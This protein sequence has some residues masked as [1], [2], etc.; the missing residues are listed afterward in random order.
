MRTVSPTVERERLRIV[1]IIA[2]AFVPLLFIELALVQSQTQAG[3]DSIAAGRLALARSVASASDTFIDGNLATLRAL[4][5]TRSVKDADVQNVNAI[6]TPILRQDPN[7][8]TFGLSSAD[9]WNLSSFTTGPHTV[10]ISD[11][12]YFQAALA[13]R[14]GVGS[15]LLTRGSL[16][17]KTIV[18]AVPVTFNDGTKGVLSGALSLVNLERQ[19][20]Q[21]VPSET[22]DLRMVDRLGHEFIG[23]NAGGDSLPDENARPEVRDGLAGQSKALVAKDTR[24]RD[25]LLAYAP[26]VK[27]GWVVILS[28]PIATAFTLPDRLGQTAFVLTL[29]GVA[30]ALAIAWYLGGR[31]ARSYVEVDLARSIAQGE[32]FRLYDALRHAPARVGLLNGPDLVYAVATPDQL[33]QVGMGEE[34]VIGK[35]F[36][37]VDPEPT[38]RAILERVYNTGEPFIAKE[39]PS[40]VRLPNGQ[41]VEGYYD[42]AIVPTHDAEGAIDGVIYYATDVT[43]LVKG[44]KRVEE[45]AAAVSAERDELQQIVNEMPEGVIVMRRNGAVMS[46]RTAEELFGHPITAND[47]PDDG[48]E[49]I[50]RNPTRGVDLNILASAA[51]VRRDGEIVA[52]VSVFQDITELRAFERQRSEF[53]SMASHEIRTPVTAIQLQ[54]DLALRQMSRG[55]SSRTEEL[56]MKARQRTKALTALI[57]DLLDVSRLDAGKFALDL[58]DVDLVEIVQKA[59]G[60]YPTDPEH[61]ILV[62]AAA[63]PL[64]VHADTRRVVEVIENL[65]NNAVKYS[66]ERGTVTVEIST[67]NDE[68]VVRVRDQGLGVPEAERGQIFERFFRTSVAKPYGGVGLGLYISKEIMTRLG[69]TITLESSSPRGSTFRVSLPL[70]PVPAPTR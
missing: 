63:K 59:A 58:H 50:V 37:A 70:A 26:A 32:R 41:L 3:R 13:G 47:D 1:A 21:V 23:A 28:E 69:G 14:D 39:M 51:P 5:N 22:I 24:G 15:V 30:A 18:L 62:V 34:D 64:T 40:S 38:H 46:N 44:R 27:A 54:L 25:G 10:N 20:G 11:R 66:P 67:E 9:G 56:I 16:N 61:P 60:E 48:E 35:P 65:V 12:D 36:S 4:T 45:L 68:A 53:F 43:D 42:A 17:T 8:L 55:D 31:L 7:W 29:L 2:L 49:I 33:D 6:F 19:L 57:N 52:A